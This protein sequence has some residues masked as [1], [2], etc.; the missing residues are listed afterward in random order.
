MLPVTVIALSDRLGWRSGLLICGIVGV[1][2]ALVLYAQTA[3]IGEARRSAGR[4]T[5]DEARSAQVLL[6]VPVVLCFV[7]FAL[8]SVALVGI[9]TFLPPT[10]GALYGMPIALATAALTG[11]L[12]GASAGVVCGGVI[13][14]RGRRHDLVVIAGLA[15]AGGLV[16]ALALVDGGPAVTLGLT[17]AAGFASGITMPS[18][19]MLV[20]AAA[21]VGA[22]GRV[23]G[24]VYSG[25]DL[26][27][28][29]TPPTMGFLID[30]GAPRGVFFIVVAALLLAIVSVLVL[31]RLAR[32]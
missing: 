21:P 18:R 11:F 20:R 25:L 29:L 6:S 8:L 24:F 17:S 4:A 15:V 16:L 5:G 23:F 10:L 30:S 14:D 9:Q 31:W 3:G 12:L 27:S 32:K 28:S 13:A 26:G 19:D 7:Y 2:L 22:T 1:A